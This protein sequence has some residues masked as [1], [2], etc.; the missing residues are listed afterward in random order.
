MI[1][2]KREQGNANVPVKLIVPDKC[3]AEKRILLSVIIA[4]PE[5]IFAK[6][7]IYRD[8]GLNRKENETFS[9]G[10]IRNR[11]R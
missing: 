3:T 2:V 8:I 9:T 7:T 6:S 10:L 11:D 4:A 5:P 1:R